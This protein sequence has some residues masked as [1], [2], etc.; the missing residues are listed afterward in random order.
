[1]TVALVF[2]ILFIAVRWAHPTHSPLPGGAGA[3]GKSGTQKAQAGQQAVRAAL[4]V[5]AASS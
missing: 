4:P 1:M 2:V 5:A 3:G